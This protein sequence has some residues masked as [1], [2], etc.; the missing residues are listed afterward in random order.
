[1][2]SIYRTHAPQFFHTDDADVVGL[3]CVARAE[4]GGEI[5]IAST[6]LVWNILQSER[7]DVAELLTQPIWYSDRKGEASVGEDPWIRTAV[8]FPEPSGQRRV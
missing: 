4:E 7:P 2:S 1:M 5:D 8:F 3:L 6:H